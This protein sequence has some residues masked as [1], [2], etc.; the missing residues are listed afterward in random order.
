MQIDANFNSMGQWDIGYFDTNSKKVSVF[1]LNDAG[2]FEI[3]AT[4]DVFASNANKVEEL[5]LTAK[6][7]DFPLIIPH[8]L[9]V[10]QQEYKNLENFLGNG[11]VILQTLEGQTVWNI[12]F[13]TKQ[14]TFLNLKMDAET[15]TKVASSNESAMLPNNPNT[16]SEDDISKL[17]DLEPKKEN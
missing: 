11:F 5:K 16:V 14:L 15:G 1:T 8:S 17:E 7:L 12:S 10:I 4:D 9:K 3:K 13:I 2:N 6:T